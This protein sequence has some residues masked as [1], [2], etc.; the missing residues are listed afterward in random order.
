ML[1]TISA[2]LCQGISHEKM[3]EREVKSRFR[4]DLLASLEAFDGVVVTGMQDIAPPKQVE[5]R[6]PDDRVGYAIDQGSR[7]L[8]NAACV[9]ILAKPNVD[10][11][12]PA[13]SPNYILRILGSSA[14]EVAQDACQCRIL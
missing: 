3:W 1:M 14:L 11:Q 13:R 2:H 4:R 12:M 7:A 6:C 9:R 8:C 10:D 5:E